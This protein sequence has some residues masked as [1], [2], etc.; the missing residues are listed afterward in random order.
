VVTSGDYQ[1]TFTVDGEKYHH[2]IDPQTLMPAQRFRSVSIV[3]ADSGLADALSTGLFLMDR[4]Q[5]QAIARQCGAEVLWVT[6]DGAEFMT[7]G[8]KS[9]LRN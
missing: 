5:G 8:L 1:R 6:A 9:Q 7:E 4:E 2:I 3:C